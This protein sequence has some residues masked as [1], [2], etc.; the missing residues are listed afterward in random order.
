MAVLDDNQSYQLI[1]PNQPNAYKDAKEYIKAPTLAITQ[2]GKIVAEQKNTGERG[3]G[4]V[5]SIGASISGLFNRGDN[6]VAANQ[7]AMAAIN[8]A[9]PVQ[10]S[11][12]TAPPTNTSQDNL[13]GF[14]QL[15]L[16]ASEEE[17]EKIRQW[18]QK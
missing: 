2:N 7:Q 8:T 16:N 13:D 18:V 5:S 12:P 4:I 17:R 1:M 11:T 3:G 9:P 14:M 10:S 15:W 6:A